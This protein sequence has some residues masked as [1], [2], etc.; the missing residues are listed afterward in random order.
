MAYGASQGRLC[1]LTVSS[2]LEVEARHGSPAAPRSRDERLGAERLPYCLRDLSWSQPLCSDAEGKDTFPCPILRCLQSLG[3]S[4]SSGITLLLP[5]RS[6]MEASVTYQE[7]HTPSLDGSL[8]LKQGEHFAIWSQ[9]PL[10]SATGPNSD[11]LTLVLQV[12]EDYCL[13]RSSQGQKRLPGLPAR[14][15][16]QSTSPGQRLC[17]WRG[18]RT[19]SPE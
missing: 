19:A 18:H 17:N 4:F 13:S 9:A 7:G 5:C 12:Q 8:A 11:W 10:L 15:G 1:F 16:V 3:E 6:H 2:Q 14:S